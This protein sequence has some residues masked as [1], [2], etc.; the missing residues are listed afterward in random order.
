MEPKKEIYNEVWFFYKK[1]LNGGRSDADWEELNREAQEIVK[2][3]NGD[4]FARELLGAV[5]NEFSRKG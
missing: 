4:M 2:K 1:Y 3:H 5:I